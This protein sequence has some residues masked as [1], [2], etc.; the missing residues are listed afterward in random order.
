MT[1][2][3]KR[4]YSPE[5]K[6]NALDLLATGDYSAASLEREL[7]ITDGRLSDWRRK[8]ERRGRYASAS[9]SGSEATPEQV[10][11]LQHQ[12]ARLQQEREVLKKALAIFSNPNQ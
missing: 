10:R 3:T 1:K 11:Q 12:V 6:Q 5:F 4:Y 8:A 2:R 9:S 7:G